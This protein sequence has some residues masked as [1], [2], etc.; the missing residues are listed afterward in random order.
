MEN[1]EDQD[2]SNMQNKGG[3]QKLISL[4]SLAFESLLSLGLDANHIWTLENPGT[5]I[6]NPKLLGWKQTLVRK[7]YLNIQGG[8]TP[9][10]TGLLADISSGL[11]LSVVKR[12]RER[13]ISEIGDDFERWWS[14]YPATD[15]FTYKRRTFGGSRAL[16]TKK[17]ECRLKFSGIVGSGK[18]TAEEMIA[19]LEEEKLNKME[20]SIRTGH[21][22]MAFFQGSS[23]YL[24]QNTYEA[25]IEA[26]KLS[27]VQPKTYESESRRIDI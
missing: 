7:G 17:D 10:G 26:I 18:Y 15:K 27:K 4:S 2:L 23:V 12:K 24:N 21:N 13:K 5:T 22:K 1:L 9:E 11:N 14:T 25:W 8:L 16:R 6:D 20:Q 3:Q 19:A